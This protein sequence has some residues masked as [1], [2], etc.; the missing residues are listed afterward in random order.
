[1]GLIGRIVEPFLKNSLRHIKTEIYTQLVKDSFQVLPPGI[2]SSPLP[3]DQGVVI[4]IDQTEGKTVA[5]GVYP[6]PQAEAGEVRLYSRDDN[7]NERSV[8]WLK[9]DG[10][11]EVNGSADNAVAFSDLKSGF[12]QLKSDFNILVGKYNAHGHIVTTP[13]TINGTAAPTTTTGTSSNANIDSSK[14]DTVK[15]P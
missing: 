15:L 6:D 5:V 13:D 10:T 3:D 14:V 8:L 12:D 2:D 9:K 4:V 11:I 1:V 7:R